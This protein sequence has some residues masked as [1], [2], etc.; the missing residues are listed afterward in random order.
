MTKIL[1][2]NNICDALRNANVPGADVLIANLTAAADTAAWALA[3]HL[4]IDHDD[5]SYEAGFGGLCVNFRPKV[6][7]DAC[8][9]VIDDGDPDGEWE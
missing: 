8:P 1:D 2:V 7:G 5:A 6:E 3:T 9:E 4:N